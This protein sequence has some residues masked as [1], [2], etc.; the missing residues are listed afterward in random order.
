MTNAKTCLLMQKPVMW[1]SA[2]K[3]REE[4]WSISYKAKKAKKGK[5][6][7]KEN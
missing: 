6:Q 7:N 1:C 2:S 5:H 4:G 3:A